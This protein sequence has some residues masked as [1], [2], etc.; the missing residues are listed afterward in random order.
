MNRFRLIDE[1]SIY[2]LGRN[3]CHITLLYKIQGK[4]FI[5]VTLFGDKLGTFC[6]HLSFS[7]VVG[8]FSNVMYL[9]SF[10]AAQH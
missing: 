10:N 8:K 1:A 5:L 6:S 7:Q 3:N 9:M 4:L 2:L